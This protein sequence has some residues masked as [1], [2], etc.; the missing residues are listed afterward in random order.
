MRLSMKIILACI[1]IA[2][3]H[4]DRTYATFISSQRSV[5]KSFFSRSPSTSTSAVNSAIEIDPNDPYARLLENYAKKGSVVKIPDAETSTKITDALSDTVK[6]ISDTNKIDIPLPDAASTTDAATATI[7]DQASALSDAIAQT[8]SDALAAAEKAAVAA[9]DVAS[10]VDVFQSTTATG[11]GGAAVKT[12]AAKVEMANKAKAASILSSG[13]V[14]TLWDTILYPKESAQANA[15]IAAQNGYDNVDKLAEM[16]EKLSLLKSNLLNVDTSLSTTIPDVKTIENNE[17]IR[18]TLKPILDN[19]SGAIDG[20]TAASL[21]L[22]LDAIRSSLQDHGSWYIT[23]LA[24]FFAAAQ[25]NAGREEARDE[26][27]SELLDSR[28]R[29]QEAAES[30]KIAAEKA[31]LARGFAQELQSLQTSEKVNKDAVMLK[32]QEMIEDGMLRQLTLEKD[33]MQKEIDNLRQLTSQLQNQITSLTTTNS[34]DNVKSTSTSASNSAVKQVVQR[35]PNED[36]KILGL[37]KEID[38]ENAKMKTT[39]TVKTAKKAKSKKKSAAKKKKTSTTT[40]TSTKKKS[41]SS[42][43][44]NH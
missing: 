35:D 28:Q 23:L 32:G 26:F 3:F 2:I 7:T 36:A 5:S 44:K 18:K 31:V 42:K 13:K 12:Y 37:L 29:V 40:A 16:R 25:K 4:S 22:D 1:L 10:K 30:A 33:L 19:T 9:S 14:P 34:F 11:A 38:E 6:T 15:Q 27:S 24:I 17:A 43:K 8:A 20:A 21:K 39:T 41:S